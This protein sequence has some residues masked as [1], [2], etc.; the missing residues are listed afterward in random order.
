MRQNQI[1]RLDA[2]VGKLRTDARAAGLATA[3][4]EGAAAAFTTTA[5]AEIDRLLHTGRSTTT[6]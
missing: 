2:M 4:A 1:A 3:D 5:T 6:G